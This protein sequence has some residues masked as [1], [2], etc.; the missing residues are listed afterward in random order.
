MPKPAEIRLK[1]LFEIDAIELVSAR[2]KGRIIHA[3]KDVSQSGISIETTLRRILQARLPGGYHVGHGHVVDKTLSSSG[4]FDVIISDSFANPFLLKTDGDSEYVPI[5]AVYA[6]GEVKSCYARKENQFEKFTKHLHELH[7][8]SR[9]PAEGNF[10]LMNGKGRGALITG[11]SSD[12]RP[13]KNP[14]FSF[15]FFCE[16]GDFKP[17]H[18]R[19]LY[20]SHDKKY[21]PSV[22]CF[23]DSGSLVYG[24][25][26]NFDKET[27]SRFHYTPE[28]GDIYDLV[29]EGSSERLTSRWLYH[30]YEGEFKMGTNLAL[31]YFLLASHVHYSTLKP[32]EPMDYAAGVLGKTR[33]R[34]RRI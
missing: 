1:E 13:R 15:M 3:T 10:Y 21:L 2:R 33:F 29:E 11:D 4:Q 25:F 34:Q 28:V 26:S 17:E 8:L 14:L 9:A 22:V 16:T 12:K 23:L 30:C 6:V 20:K 18:V 24:Q 31:L 27:T 19:D 7:S 32:L 5:E